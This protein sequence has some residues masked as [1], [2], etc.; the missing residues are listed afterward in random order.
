MPSFH[1]EWQQLTALSDIQYIT[2]V[3]TDLLGCIA[4][5]LVSERTWNWRQPA[6]KQ[7]RSGKAIFS[8]WFDDRRQLEMFIGELLN[9]LLF[10]LREL[11]RLN[12]KAN[13][14]ALTCEEMIGTLQ[15]SEL[16]H[17]FGREVVLQGFNPPTD[18]RECFEDADLF[19]ETIVTFLRSSVQYDT[20]IPSV[21]RT[22]ML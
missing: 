16:D 13:T 2:I 9:R 1:R 11:E 14:I 8:E 22:L 3:R 19:R 4:S 17:F 18:Y 12:A 10:D 15:S 7:L 6:R 21:L 5:M 20:F